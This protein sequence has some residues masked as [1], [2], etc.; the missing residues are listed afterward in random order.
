MWC[1]PS[2]PSV[3]DELGHARQRGGQRPHLSSFASVSS[4][5][6]GG[7]KEPAEL[8]EALSSIVSRRS[9]PPHAADGSNG[10]LIAIPPPRRPSAICGES[11]SGLVVTTCRGRR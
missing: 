11:F 4:G 7:L 6:R 8:S 3:G 1:A 9:R 2:A 10:S 5:D